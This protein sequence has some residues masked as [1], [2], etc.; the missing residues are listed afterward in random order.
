V[1]VP[2]LCKGCGVALDG[3]RRRAYC[4]DCRPRK[5]ERARIDWTTILATDGPAAGYVEQ[6]TEEQD[7]LPPLC[8][9]LFYW[10]VEAGK[11]GRFF[12][13]NDLSAYNVLGRKTAVLRDRLQFPPL[14]DATRTISTRWRVE[15]PDAIFAMIEHALGLADLTVGQE[16]Q[17]W[18]AVEKRGLVPRLERA[19][20]EPLGIP[21]IPLGGFASQ[22]LRAQVRQ[23]IEEDGRPALLFYA[24]DLDPSGW[25]I[26][27]TFAAKS[28]P[29]QSIT[30]VALT[31]AQA[32]KHKIPPNPA[33]SK[34]PRLERFIAET[35]MREQMEVNALEVVRPG[36]LADLFRQAIAPNWD[37]E[38]HARALR[39]EQEIRDTFLP[40]IRR[41]LGEVGR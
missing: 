26:G 7:G 10:L 11:D 30:R 4:A 3:R 14:D 24:V 33:P 41:A 40:V 39:R 8:R 17:I 19:L 22:P 25:F 31:P 38:A 32:K 1:S 16:F 2:L 35:G 27:R 36:P 15:T 18:A 12:F 5:Q 20:T 13:P 28:G 23:R 37:D 21:V 34:D 9:D 6:A 29:W